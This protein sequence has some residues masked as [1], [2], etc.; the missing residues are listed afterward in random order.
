MKGRVNLKLHVV[1]ICHVYPVIYIV[2][3]A[4]LTQICPLLGGVYSPTTN[5]CFATVNAKP[6]WNTAMA[7]CPIATNGVFPGVQG[8]LVQ[9]KTQAT[10]EVAKSACPSVAICW[11]AL[12][13][14]TTDS[15]NVKEWF[16]YDDATT[17]TDCF[18][19]TYWPPLA[20][21]LNARDQD[22][23]IMAS[24]LDVI[25]DAPC[26]LSNLISPLCEFST[27]IFKRMALHKLV[28]FVPL[29]L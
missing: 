8:R 10:F 27:G 20:V 6:D 26:S 4:V 23:G 1:H 9:T 5:T 14:P 12:K 25:D 29:L 11:I 18:S 21:T 22:C 3:S 24:G 13:T 2:F 15:P 19:T 7:T 28:I 16:W 17:P